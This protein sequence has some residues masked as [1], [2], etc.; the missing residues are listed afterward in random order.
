M[1]AKGYDGL[2]AWNRAAINPSKQF[3]WIPWGSGEKIEEKIEHD[4]L[5]A[6]GFDKVTA[7][8]DRVAINC[9]KKI[10]RH[11]GIGVKNYK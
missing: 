1:L 5:L 3:S 8:W 11:C 2:T 6:K 10:W 9:K 7:A 4:L